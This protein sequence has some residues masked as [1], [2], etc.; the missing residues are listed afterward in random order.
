[1]WRTRRRGLL[2]NAAIALGNRLAEGTGGEARARGLEALRLALADPEP[3]VRGAGAWALGRSG[4][5]QAV[6]WL[7]AAL[8]GER[9]A[10][11]E[12]EL[13]A[14]LEALAARTP[15]ENPP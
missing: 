2:R 6:P 1:V 13:R 7:A 14:A 11:V 12:Q 3:L 8:D 4:A 5:A 10:T 9:D 15:T